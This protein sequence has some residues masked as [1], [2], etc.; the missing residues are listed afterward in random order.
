ML[1][2]VSPRQ[3]QVQPLDQAPY[4]GCTQDY[5]AHEA[6]QKYQ[7][8]ASALCGQQEEGAHFHQRK[9]REEADVTAFREDDRYVGC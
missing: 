4:P 1:S 9:D 2:C 7:R 6:D 8:D 5:E 3:S